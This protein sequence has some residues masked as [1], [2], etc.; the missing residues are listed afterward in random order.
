V[1]GRATAEDAS[2]GLPSARLLARGLAA[3]R[4]FVGLILFANGLAKLTG[5]TTI[6]IGAYQANLIDRDATR[7]ILRY[8]GLENPAN[9]GPGTEVPGLKSVVRFLLDNFGVVQWLIT[10][11]ELG[12]GLLLL[13]G[14]ASR[15]AALLAL[16]QQLFLALLYASSN[17]WL[18]EQPHEYVPLLILAIVPAGRVWGL[19]GRLRWPPARAGRWPF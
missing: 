19:D 15:G 10:A 4:I 16:A 17:R 14:L 8:E 18:F 6:T 13:V 9:G 3:L 1:I 12:L 5:I 11:A 2:V 7:F